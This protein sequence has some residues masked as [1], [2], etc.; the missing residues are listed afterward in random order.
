[1]HAIVHGLVQ[2]VFFRDFTRHHAERLGLS[3]YVRNL[4]D[5]TVEVSAEGEREKL[6][7]L[8][9]KLKVG[10][11]SAHVSGVFVTWSTYADAYNGFMVR[12]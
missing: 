12:Y 2:G 4:P 1:M 9:E 6:A 8:A 10:P 7:E 5:G 3:G 11:P